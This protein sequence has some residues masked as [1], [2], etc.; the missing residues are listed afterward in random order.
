MPEFRNLNINLNLSD[1]IIKAIEL[2]YPIAFFDGLLYNK[3]II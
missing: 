3:T 2:N 1:I